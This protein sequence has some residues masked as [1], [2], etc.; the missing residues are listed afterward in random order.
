MDHANFKM[1]VVAC[2]MLL[3]KCSYVF[4]MSEVEY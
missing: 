3:G 1:F 4:Y 2:L